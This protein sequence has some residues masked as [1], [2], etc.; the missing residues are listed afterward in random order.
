MK[1]IKLFTK[2]D[3]YFVL[4]LLLVAALG[5]LFAQHHDVAELTVHFM[6]YYV[7]AAVL[8]CGMFLWMRASR[9]I[10]ILNIL[11]V[12]YF[13]LPIVK[14]VPERDVA[15]H[16][17]YEDIAIAQYNVRYNNLRGANIAH[18]LVQQQTDVVVLQEMTPAI[19]A[20]MH[21]LRDAYPYIFEAPQENPFGMVLLSRLPIVRVERKKTPDGWNH[22][23]QAELRTLHHHLPIELV[24]IH[25][26][27][28]MPDPYA[29][30]RNEQMLH[31]A[32]IIADAPSS[33][34]KIVMGDLNCTPYS[35]WF[36]AMQQQSQLSNVM[37]G[38]NIAGTWPNFVPAWLRI[39]IDHMLVSRNIEL[40]ERRVQ[41]DMGSDHLPIIYKLRVYATGV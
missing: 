40:L 6:Q 9:W 27:P 32:T 11:L 36:D 3:C 37:Q 5:I 20:A 21:E 25:T 28:P 31:V 1:K 13:L 15:R 33:H 34:A 22:Y 38:G 26:I 4:Y 7:V 19:W 39:P 29:K 35:P 30:Q 8:L 41:Q 23:V 18:W 10:I 12:A 14:L 2:N 24:E 17:V 16:E